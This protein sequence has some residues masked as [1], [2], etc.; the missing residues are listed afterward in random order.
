MNSGDDVLIEA[1]KAMTIPVDEVLP[2]EGGG[3]SLSHVSML[4]KQISF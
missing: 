4:M 3:E 2:G 1:R